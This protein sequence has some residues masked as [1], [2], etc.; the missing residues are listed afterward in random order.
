MGTTAGGLQLAAGSK[1]SE[2]GGQK[3][4]NSEHLLFTAYRLPLTVYR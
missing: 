4:A 2:V 1:K 3:S